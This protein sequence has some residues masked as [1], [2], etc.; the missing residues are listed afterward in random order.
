[1]KT[2][3]MLISLD[4]AN[5]IEKA[6]IY[7]NPDTKN[8]EIQNGTTL[9]SNLRKQGKT[10]EE[11]KSIL[12]KDSS[13]IVIN[14]LGGKVGIGT[15]KPVAELEVAGEIKAEK[16]SVGQAN[17]VFYSEGEVLPSG[18]PGEEFFNTKEHQ[19]YK[20]LGGKWVSVFKC[21]EAIC[22]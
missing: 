18:M 8:V 6:V 15:E 5:N 10:E 17:L 16:F 11:I 12:F 7:W 3:S 22:L 14:G 21:A 13:S 2:Q 1:M 4:D 20:F 19:L 9:I